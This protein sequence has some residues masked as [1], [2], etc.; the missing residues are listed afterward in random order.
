VVARIEA[1][2]AREA[3]EPLKSLKAAIEVVE[4]GRPDAVGEQK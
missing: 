3:S 4:R 2:P 1:L